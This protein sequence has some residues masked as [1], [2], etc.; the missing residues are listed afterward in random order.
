M[1][2]HRVDLLERL[3]DELWGR[4]NDNDTTMTHGAVESLMSRL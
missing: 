1:I 2:Q 4:Q 3:L